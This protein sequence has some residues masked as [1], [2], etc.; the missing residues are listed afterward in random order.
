[1]A[2]YVVGIF[3]IFVMILFVIPLLVEALLNPHSPIRDYFV[4]AEKRWKN[5][6]LKSTY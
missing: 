5:A 4:L 2:S 3:T 1:M 6:S